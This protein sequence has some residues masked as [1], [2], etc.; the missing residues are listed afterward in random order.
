[1]NGSLIIAFA[2][3]Y[4]AEQSAYAPFLTPAY[5]E[6]ASADPFRVRLVN[7]LPPEVTA[8]LEAWQGD[9]VANP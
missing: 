6:A 9:I 4:G 8:Q 3:V 7:A 5:V 2:Q 1:M